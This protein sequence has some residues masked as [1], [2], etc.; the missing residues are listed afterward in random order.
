[1]SDHNPLAVGFDEVFKHHGL[2]VGPDECSSDVYT[3]TQSEPMEDP[4]TSFTPDTPQNPY[5]PYTASLRSPFVTN[6]RSGS[7]GY[8]LTASAITPMSSGQSNASKSV[9][10]R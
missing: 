8:T 2:L 6:P 4:Y 10:Q 5:T 9:V 7:V 1:M 3:A